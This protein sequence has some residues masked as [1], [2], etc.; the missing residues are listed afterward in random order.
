MGITELNQLVHRYWPG[1][2]A[3]LLPHAYGFAAHAHEGQ[4]RL[5][6]SPYVQHPLEVAGILGEIESDPPTVAAGLLHDTLEDTSV[7]PGDLETEFGL[8]IRSLVEGVTKLTRTNF[9]TRQEEQASNLRK[10]FVAMADDV[11]VILIKLGD[12]LHNMRTLA[13]LA[14]ERQE[15]IAEETL[16]IYAPLAHRLGVRRLKWEL[17]DLA[18]KVLHPE[19]YEEIAGRIGAHQEEREESVRR[20]VSDLEA[21]LAEAGIQARV[22]G[23][24]KHLFSIYQKMLRQ[25]IDFDQLADLMAV[26]VVVDSVP[27]C[28]AAVG[29]VHKLWMPITGHFADYIAKPKS[30]GYQ[31]LHTKVLG[32][33]G[34]PMEVQIRTRE[35]HRV[36]EHGIAAHWRYKEG[37]RPSRFDEQMMEWLQQLADLEVQLPE[38]HEWLELVRLDLFKDQ[39]FVFTPQW[40]VIDLP[41]GAGPLDFAY[42]I[43]TDVGNHCAGAKVNGKLVS[44]DY[45]F[46]NGDIVEIITHPHARPSLDWLKLIVAS[47]AKSKVR[48]YL[49]AQVRE[50]NIAAGREAIERAIRRLP[51][52]ERA[53]AD[54]D[55][56]PAVAAALNLPDVDSVYA[57]VGFGEIEPETVVQRLLPPEE[58][59]ETLAQELEALGELAPVPAEPV[60][61][62]QVT[63]GSIEGLAA[64]P[65]RCCNPLPGDP[66]VGYIT[67]GQG[68]AIHRADCKNLLHR[69][70]REP[71][72]VHPLTWGGTPAGR[73]YRANIEV[74]ALDRVG[75]LSHITAIVSEMGLNI[76]SATVDTERS[77]VATIRLGVDV[78]GRADLSRLVER[79]GSLIDVISARPV[80]T[81]SPG[82][83]APRTKRRRRAVRRRQ[84]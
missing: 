70:A 56:L 20:A 74:V 7:K 27:E 75:L 58:P 72:R 61:R 71:E 46:Q 53:R 6:G 21:A 8:Q 34:Q 80:Q 49:R 39:V 63:L 77:N 3:N 83:T 62:A 28:Y 43:H 50:E 13:P 51:P 55:A 76:S 14:L 84:T 23:R 2:E 18:F 30:N 65:A 10:M 38:Q 35:M 33:E 37:G 59:P 47:S 25:S 69:A 52:D 81:P 11:R 17:E 29:I 12:R 19:E 82:P 48:R 31:S 45:R 4:R 57:A 9:R 15:A 22:Q 40:D 78:E 66:I 44:L 60:G 1:A 32:S 5:D 42:R 16:F 36:A 26:R 24:P 64:R 79:L 73:C 67:R 54:L 68:L 41:A